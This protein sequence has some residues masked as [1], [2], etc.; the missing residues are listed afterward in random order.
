VTSDTPLPL[1]HPP[2]RV[3]IVEDQA[4]IREGLRL[5]VDDARAFVCVGTYGSV[6]EA[7]PGLARNRADIVLMDLGLPG[8]S[9]LEGMRRLKVRD[10]DVRLVALTVYDDDDRVFNAL[11]AG[12]SGYLLKTT[13]PAR[14]ME[15]LEE[16]TR[17]GASISPEV[18]SRVLALFRELRR[19][20]DQA[21]SL[22][23]HELRILQLL[24]EGHSYKTTAAALSSSVHTVAFHMKNIYAKLEV[25]SKS[26]AVAKALRHRLVK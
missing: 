4:E 17:G 19:P 13:P 18:A 23:P 12:A 10:P 11:C 8:V 26:E 16:V 20:A 1:A 3:A 21:H 24:A 2:T 5:L 15:C 6:E 7:M 22:T 9:G 14:L 25:H